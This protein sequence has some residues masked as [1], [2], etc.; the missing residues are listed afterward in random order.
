VPPA[1]DASTDADEEPARRAPEASPRPQPATSPPRV[2]AP[3]ERTREQE[4]PPAEK[5][6]AEAAPPQPS[7][8]RPPEDATDPNLRQ[9]ADIPQIEATGEVDEIKEG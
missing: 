6:A 1:G 4:S 8:V 9:L 5:R 3:E 7:P 2:E